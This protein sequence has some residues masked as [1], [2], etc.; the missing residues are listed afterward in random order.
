MVNNVL[1]RKVFAIDISTAGTLTTTLHYDFYKQKNKNWYM[2]STWYICNYYP[3]IVIKKAK[4]AKN[5]FNKKA[6]T[7]SI[8]TTSII[9]TGTSVINTLILTTP[10]LQ[11]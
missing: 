2:K 5:I 3:H 8:S 6:L 10:T 4:T 1:D 7:T 11:F 9:T